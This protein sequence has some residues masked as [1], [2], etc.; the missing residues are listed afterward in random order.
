MFQKY[1]LFLLSVFTLAGAFFLPLKSAAAGFDRSVVILMYHRFGEDSYPSTNIRMDQF[2][3]HLNELERGEYNV[4]P[5]PEIVDALAN[6][7]T[8]PDRTIGITIDDAF[9]SVY[10]HAYPLLKDRDFPFTVFVSTGAISETAGSYMSW[11]QLRDMADNRL[12]TLGNHLVSHSSAITLSEE[13]LRR[14][15]NQ[16]QITLREQIGVS[17]G[18]FSYPYGEYST[19][20]VNIVKNSR[21]QAAFGQHSSTIGGSDDLFTLP[22]YALNEN[23][24]NIERFRLI[25]NSLPLPVTDVTPQNTLLTSDN[26]PPLYGFTVHKSIKNLDNLRCYASA[27]GDLSLQRLGDRRFEIRFEKPFPAGRSRINC[28]TL[29]P[30]GRWRWFGRQFV[31]VR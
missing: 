11:D 8:L 21:F 27:G 1:I 24:S 30:V 13:E 5:V 3:A 31:T 23:F 12:V 25:A 17:P 2:Q 22:R 7:Q 10:R 18:L 4:M 29:D 19:E 28:T 15:I 16:A 20:T 6:N 14:E 9:L 26:N